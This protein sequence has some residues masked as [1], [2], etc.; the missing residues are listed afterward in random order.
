[1]NFIEEKILEKGNLNK[2]K[3]RF[4]P[5]PNGAILNDGRVVGGLHLGHAKSIILNFGL[6]EKYNAPCVLRFDDTNPTTERKE[7]VDSMIE[8][9]KWLGYTP[10]EIRYTSD[11][12]DFLYECAVTLIKKGLAYVDDS[13]S[14]EIANLKGTPTSVG[15]DSPYKSRSIEENLDLFNRMR[16]GEFS[17][18]SKIL[19]ANIDMT[20][21]NMIL[22]DPVIYRVISKSHHRTGD[23]WKIYPMYDFAH[24]LSDYK[25]GITDSLCT[26]EFE[27]HRPLYMWVLENCDLENPLPEETEFA[28]LNI[29]YTVMSKRKLKRLVEEGYVTGWDDPRMPTISGL[30]RRGFTPNAIKDFCDRIS[31]TRKDG[32]VSYLL[33]EECLRTDLNKTSYRLMCV[34]DPI[35]L[36]ISNWDSGTEM[37]EVENNPGDETAGTRMVPFSGELWI[38]REDFSINPDKKYN[39]LKPGGEVRLK[40]GY[41]IKAN[42]YI[43]DDRNNIIEVICTYDPLSKSG[44]TIDRKIKGTIHWVSIEHGVNVEIRNYDKLFNVSNPN[45]SDDFKDSININSLSINER[46]IIEPYI[47]EYSSLYPIQMVRKGYYM[48]DSKSGNKIIFNRSVSL[49]E[50]YK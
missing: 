24:P 41:V 2:L 1:M 40:S 3:L 33:L 12:F 16:L 23:T 8:D 28:R 18:G 17:E 37:V 22:R 6:A 11:Y 29:D 34:L 35:K 44:M 46:S 49:K 38:E 50:S 43:T 26:L 15:K 47:N 48:I 27:V 42:D 7:F 20:S 32:V 5:E 45:D 13:T 36:T 19:R 30:R 10:S 9:I 25:E 14:E 21:P 31:V 39:R 4:P